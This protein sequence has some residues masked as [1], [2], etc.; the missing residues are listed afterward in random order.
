MSWTALNGNVTHDDVKRLDKRLV[1][2]LKTFV[3]IDYCDEK[4]VIS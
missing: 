1:E 2:K 3:E 4:K